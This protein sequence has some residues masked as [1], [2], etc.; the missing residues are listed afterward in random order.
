[1]T[2]R[3]SVLDQHPCIF[4]LVP[5]LPRHF[6]CFLFLPSFLFI[7]IITWLDNLPVTLPVHKGCTLAARP[8]TL[9]TCPVCLQ[10]N[11]LLAFCPEVFSLF[12]TQL[13]SRRRYPNFCTVSPLRLVV[14]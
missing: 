14:L 10:Y 6:S 9:W 8:S 13:F 7:R 5:N 2:F 11:L 3:E 1:M 4:Y 12:Y